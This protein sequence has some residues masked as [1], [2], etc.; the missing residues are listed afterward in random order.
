MHTGK[1]MEKL[2]DTGS[3][4]A[5][6]AVV[7]NGSFADGARRLGLTRSAAGKAIARLEEL[8]G[9][10]LLHRTTRRIGLTAEG[11]L[12]YREAVQILSDLE[13]AQA[14]FQRASGEPRGVLRIT[15]TE[16]Y[17]RQVILTVIAS[18]LARWPAVTSE[19]YSRT[20]LLI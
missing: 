13:D 1:A 14:E 20:V 12:F 17:G 10:R 3:L 11:Q 19:N 18:F 2:A 9:A 15:A 8:L 6:V 5:F 7:E 16:A 4:R